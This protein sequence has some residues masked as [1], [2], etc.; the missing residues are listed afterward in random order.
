MK[1]AE[2]HTRIII[3]RFQIT[4][5][6]LN[7]RLNIPG[8]SLAAWFCYY[9]ILRSVRDMVFSMYLARY[10]SISTVTAS[11]ALLNFSK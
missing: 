11:V 10:D 3:R 6:S 2:T 4:S 1:L 5:L 8:Y 9:L 7:R